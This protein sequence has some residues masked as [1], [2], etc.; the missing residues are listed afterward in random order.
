MTTNPN[1]NPTPSLV[2]SSTMTPINKNHPADS[3]AKIGGN[4]LG[5]SN[6]LINSNH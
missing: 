6:C 3:S 5:I 2:I 4:S 1:N